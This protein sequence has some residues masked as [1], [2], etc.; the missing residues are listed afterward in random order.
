VPR[1]GYG[2]AYPTAR[3]R[4]AASLGP[5]VADAGLSG[6]WKAASL[7]NGAAASWTSLDYIAQAVSQATGANQPTK[8]ATGLVFDGT[9]SLT[10]TNQK[11]AFVKGTQ[12][13]DLVGAVAGRGVVCT[14]LA[15]A[16]DGT[17]WMTSHGDQSN[18]RDG[19]GTFAPAL[20]HFGKNADGTIDMS[21]VLLN[22][23]L[24]TTYSGIGSVQGIVYD[25]S[26]DT[27]WIADNLASKVRHVALDGSAL[28]GDISPG[29]VPNGIARDHANDI[30]WVWQE[31]GAGSTIG[32][33]NCATGALIGSTASMPR[34][35]ADHLFFDD[36]SRTLFASYG[37]NGSPCSIDLFNVDGTALY[38]LIG[39]LTLTECDA[40]EGFVVVPTLTGQKIIICN[41]ADYHR[42]SGT[43]PTLNRVLE[44]N[45]AKPSGLICDI[46]GKVIVPTTTG[47]DAIFTIGDPLAS[48][49]TGLGLYTAG[50]TD[51]R[52]FANDGSTGTTHQISQ[53]FTVSSMA[54]VAKVFYGRIDTLNDTISMWIGGTLVTASTG[55][56]A[57]L[58]PL[59]GGGTLRIGNAAD[60][61]PPTMTL[62]GI[63]LSFRDDL[64]N[65]PRTSWETY[66]AGL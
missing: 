2:Y 34:T 32:K 7:S 12:V 58:G 16:P 43:N 24:A 65:D 11:T 55:K 64:T 28:S 19:S 47:T 13:P 39:T 10:R 57:Y 6:F 22:Y 25:K 54:T 38:F 17:F 56:S 15:I 9:D 29:Y 44:F 26:D 8:G 35:Q 4:I 46:F 27:L 41:D 20:M 51:L 49:T 23:N 66:L 48:A 5:P 1:Y 3:P 21:N 53:T 40:N 18:N 37:A 52:L 30:M 62:L 45:L 42:S 33:F 63:G 36:S 60:T 31:A 14:G 50:A 61:R 59:G